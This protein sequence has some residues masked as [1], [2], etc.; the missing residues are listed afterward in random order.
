ELSGSNGLLF[1]RNSKTGAIEAIARE[2]AG[3]QGL[4]T[5]LHDN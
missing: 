1:R 5:D 3:W 2:G 4:N